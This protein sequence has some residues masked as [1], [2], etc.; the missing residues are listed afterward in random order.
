MRR[1]ETENFFDKNWKSYL[2][3]GTTF[4]FGDQQQKEEIM[5]LGI[6]PKD[7]V[8][9]V[10]IGWGNSINLIFQSCPAVKKV[11][12]VDSS[13]TMLE[14]S[15]KVFSNDK[16]AVRR[17]VKGIDPK[18]AIYLSNLNRQVR[19]RS[20]HVSFFFLPAEKVHA[21]GVKADK[22]AAT[23]GFHWLEPPQ[24]NSFVSF[25]RSLRAGGRVT[26]STASAFFESRLNSLSFIENPFYQAFFDEFGTLCK[27]TAHIQKR[28]LLRQKNKFTFNKIVSIIKKAGFMLENYREHIIV[29]P[30]IAIKKLCLAGIKFRYDCDEKNE[31]IKLISSKAIK[32][33][34][35]KFVYSD[36]SQQLEICPIFTIKKIRDV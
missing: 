19:P 2:E 8:I 4:K 1:V 30:K 26:F 28:K 3:H 34:E 31:E 15:K 5:D 35:N 29:I 20:K 24:I 18:T 33:A 25:N 16:K 7:T 10:G 36:Y 22:I 12:A 27:P 23:M 32:R 14:L 11:I 6:Q 17:L 21:L 13:K 9:N